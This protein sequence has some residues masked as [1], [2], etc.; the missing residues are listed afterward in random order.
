MALIAI[1]LDNF[2]T[3]CEW[4]VLSPT[5]FSRLCMSDLV[6]GHNLADIQGRSQELIL[7]EANKID[8]LTKYIY[9][10]DEM[11]AQHASRRRRRRRGLVW[12]GGVPPSIVRSFLKM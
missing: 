1:L 7:Y 9:G 5:I 3:L 12:K 10:K 6:S 11:R 8:I 4:P 2:C